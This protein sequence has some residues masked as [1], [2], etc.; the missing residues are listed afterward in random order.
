MEKKKKSSTVEI[1]ANPAFAE[2]CKEIVDIL[3]KLYELGK[4]SGLDALSA[5]DAVGLSMRQY[6][7]SI[8]TIKSGKSPDGL[9]TM[10]ELSYAFPKAASS[11]DALLRLTGAQNSAI[12]FA[13]NL[14]VLNYKDLIKLGD[15]KSNK[16]DIKQMCIILHQSQALKPLLRDPHTYV[17]GGTF[18]TVFDNVLKLK[19]DL[20]KEHSIVKKIT[21]QLFHTG[22]MVNISEE[23]GINVN[24]DTLLEQI[25]SKLFRIKEKGLSD[26]QIDMIYEAEIRINDYRS[27]ADIKSSWG[28]MNFVSYL[29]LFS[30]RWYSVYKAYIAQ[31][32]LKDDNAI[33]AKKFLEDYHKTPKAE[34]AERFKGVTVK[35]SAENL[36]SMSV[37][38][39]EIVLPRLAASSF[40][41]LE[42]HVQ[43]ER[44]QAWDR[45]ERNVVG[46]LLTS[47]E[48]AVKENILRS[49][50]I[51]KSQ[52]EKKPK[53]KPVEI[54]E[55]HY[56]F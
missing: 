39:R 5:V 53:N 43:L 15:E 16:R 32:S 47:S 21:K 31:K 29:K 2:G 46:A 25:L 56:V 13:E 54:I 26:E 11:S 41:Q 51:K 3:Q 35:C 12:S 24:D 40:K 37:I 36:H 34:I 1:I 7:K 28:A 22:L 55:E 9:L 14:K 10:D 20:I 44:V 6:L 48:Q 19:E 27:K 38:D 49:K 4:A 30:N 45:L 42:Y 33:L 8:E 18:S 23:M 50:F 52:S 17:K